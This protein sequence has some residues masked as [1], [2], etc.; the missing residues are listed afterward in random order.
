[1]IERSTGAGLEVSA[2]AFEASSVRI[3]LAEFESTYSITFA[4]TGLSS[5]LLRRLWCH[6]TCCLSNF[7]GGYDAWD[8]R[9]W[10]IQSTVSDTRSRRLRRATQLRRQCFGSTSVQQ[11]H[12]S[13]C[14]NRRKVNMTTHE[15]RHI[16]ILRRRGQWKVKKVKT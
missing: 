14:D 2:L 5:K 6:N 8:Y 11:Q 3:F 7:V 12:M 4:L 1:M 15:A 10:A 9:A 13:L 16:F